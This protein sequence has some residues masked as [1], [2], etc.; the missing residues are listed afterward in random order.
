[1]D[2]RLSDS[3]DSPSHTI[4]QCKAWNTYYVGL[5]LVRELQGVRSLEESREAIFMT[6]GSYVDEA[7]DFAKQ[8][9]ITLIDGPQIME[10][11]RGLHPEEQA[12]LFKVATEG[13]YKT[14]TCPSCGIKMVSRTK[15]NGDGETFWGCRNYG[16]KKPG[17][18]RC[19]ITLRGPKNQQPQQQARQEPSVARGKYTAPRCPSCQVDMVM[20]R[21]RSTGQL[22]WGCQNFSSMGCRKMFPVEE[23]S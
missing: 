1:M 12:R 9:R 13:D 7:I 4:I 14:P 11:I 5:K 23:R 2:V 16:I 8:A 22:F 15:R 21:S 18:K 19:R 3:K 6:S 10:M 17:A 20:R